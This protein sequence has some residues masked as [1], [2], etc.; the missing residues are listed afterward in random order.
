MQHLFLPPL[1]GQQVPGCSTPSLKLL[2][3]LCQHEG[4]VAVRDG[5]IDVPNQHA[6]GG[7]QV[8]HQLLLPACIWLWSS[9]LS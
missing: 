4:A 8:L 1:L 7:G 9:V 2:E 3:S 6:D 5:E